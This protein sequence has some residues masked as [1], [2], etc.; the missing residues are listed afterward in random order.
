MCTD[1]TNLNKA[2][3]KD[4][5]PLPC[6]GRLVDGSVGHEVFDF[7]DASSGYHQILLNDDDQEKNGFHNGVMS[8]LLESD[9]VRIDECRGYLSEGGESSVQG[10]DKKKYGD[11]RRRYSS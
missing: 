2:C 7:L 10:T 6:L 9:A 4:Y 11:I 5:Y 8:L 1:F 3:P